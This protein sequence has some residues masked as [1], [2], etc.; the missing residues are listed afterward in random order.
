MHF[1]HP[2]LKFKPAGHS[3]TIDLVS[4]YSLYIVAL[5]VL[6]LF[7]LFCF[8]VGGL[9][10]VFYLMPPFLVLQSS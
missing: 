8:F 9:C 5:I 7:F 4:L 10:L 3:S 6:L 2:I 1:S